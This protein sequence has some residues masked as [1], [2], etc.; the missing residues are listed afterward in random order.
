MHKILTAAKAEK[1]SLSEFVVKKLNE[2]MNNSW[3]DNFE[4]LF[5]AISDTSFA[6]VVRLNYADRGGPHLLDRILRKHWK[7]TNKV[8]D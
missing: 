6:E 5:G 1:L 7:A 4:S 3:P 8:L 2:S